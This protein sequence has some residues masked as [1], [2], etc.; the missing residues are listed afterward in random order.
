MYTDLCRICQV[1]FILHTTIQVSDWLVCCIVYAM[2]RNAALNN[3]Y[4][5]ISLCSSKECMK[6]KKIKKKITLL[7]H[8]CYD[9]SLEEIKSLVQHHKCL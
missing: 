9:W 1:F 6:N 3:E 2:S 4:E 5:R 8:S 7:Y